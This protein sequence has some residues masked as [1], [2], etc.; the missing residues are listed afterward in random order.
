MH[1]AN[2]ATQLSPQAPEKWF[3]HFILIF[4]HV[5]QIKELPALDVFYDQT[6]V[7][8]SCK[9]VKIGDDRRMRN[10]LHTQT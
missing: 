2:R 8:R 4:F 10:M 9:R 7:G 5:D 6:M 3:R 1:P